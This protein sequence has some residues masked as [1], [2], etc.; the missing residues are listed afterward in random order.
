M[1]DRKGSGESK[2]QHLEVRNISD[3][4]S[5]L[6]TENAGGMQQIVDV[7]FSNNFQENG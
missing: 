7:F 1:S 2:T 3:P 6:H 5:V 4:F